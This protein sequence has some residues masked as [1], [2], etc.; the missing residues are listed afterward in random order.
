MAI[1]L[2]M[3]HQNLALEDGNNRNGMKVERKNGGTP[4]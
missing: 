3:A 1:L 2:G 4:V